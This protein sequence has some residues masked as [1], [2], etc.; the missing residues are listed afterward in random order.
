MEAESR[1]FLIEVCGLALAVI[2]LLWLIVAAFRV[3]WPWG[4]AMLVFLP[5]AAPIF[6]VHHFRKAGW[7][8]RVLAAGLAIGSAPIAYD[9]L[10]P[11][12]LDPFEKRVGGELHLTLTGWDRK[13]YSILA[14][15]PGTIVLQMAN[16]DV[17]DATLVHL[18]GMT[19]LRELELSKTQVDDAGLKELEPIA[20][21]ETLRLEGTRIT[22][23]GFRKWL[24]PRESLNQLDLRG[25]AVTKEAGQA[26]QNAKAGRRLLQ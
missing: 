24:S 3:K 13:D 9:K 2:G 10:T 23:E 18:K 19:R 11:I 8:L 4:L 17:T 7:P 26:W 12:D 15:R 5:V 16:P 20:G 21:L 22:D 25:T 14:A 6:T 1:L